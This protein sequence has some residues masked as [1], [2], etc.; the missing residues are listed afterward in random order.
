MLLCNIALFF[1]S[2]QARRWRICRNHLAGEIIWTRK[3][4]EAGL[5]IAG[6]E[7]PGFITYFIHL[8]S[9]LRIG[10]R[11]KVAACLNEPMVCAL[12]TGLDERPCRLARVHSLLRGCYSIPACA[13]TWRQR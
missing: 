12:I 13:W 10:K 8:L 1:F 2:G 9:L 4:W 6:A 11:E 7:D 3:Q 5:N